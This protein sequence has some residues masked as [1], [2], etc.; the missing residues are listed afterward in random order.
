MND[1]SEASSGQL[2]AKLGEG[3]MELAGWPPRS[4][5]G[6]SENRASWMVT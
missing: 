5:A 6:L 1:R 3:E 2:A 4:K